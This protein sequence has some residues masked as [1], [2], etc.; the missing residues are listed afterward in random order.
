MNR[1]QAS[2]ETPPIILYDEDDI[3]DGIRSCSK[4]LIGK[5]LTTKPIHT[6]SL[7]SAL[8][9]IWCNPKGFR[10]EECGSKTFQFLFEEEADAERILS[11]NPWLFRNSWLVLKKWSRDFKYERLP[12]FCYT[13]GLIGHEEEVCTNKKNSPDKEDTDTHELG[14]WMRAAQTG[15]KLNL[16]PQSHQKRQKDWGSKKNKN[17]PHDVTA[18][19]EAL[20]VN[21]NSSP[22]SG[23]TSSDR[24]NPTLSLGTEGSIGA[25]DGNN[26]CNDKAISEAVDPLTQATHDTEAII[27]VP[28][29]PLFKISLISPESQRP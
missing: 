11:N 17:F 13:F 8:S 2:R 10:V 1:N 9:G 16:S 28:T 22:T 14:P 24:E 27:S 3:S 29:S 23:D 4:S 19:L 12:Q 5:I 18:L 15:R 25:A 20:S 7:Q 6:N 26:T 21:N